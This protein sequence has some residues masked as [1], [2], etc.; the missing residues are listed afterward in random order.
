V[1]LTTWKEITWRQFGA[2]IDMLG[3]AI[4]ACPD[5]VW[6]DRSQRPEFWYTVFHTLFFLD[7]YLS[8]SDVGFSPPAPFTLDEIDV[9][10]LLPARVY[11]KEELRQYLDH[12][13]RKCRATLAAT[14]TERASQR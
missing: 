12:G 1:D 13:R 14:T 10:G 9:R 6:S 7:L 2:A 3:N 11:A 4:E 5:G 8:E